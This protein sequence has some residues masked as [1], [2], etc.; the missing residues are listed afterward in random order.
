MRLYVLCAISL[1]ACAFEPGGPTEPDD[2]PLPDPGIPAD[3]D[4][5]VVDDPTPPDPP[6]APP[7]QCRV[8]NE[9]LGVVGLQVMG[10]Q[11]LFTFQAWKLGHGKPVGFTLTGP[12]NVRYE[13]RT[14][15]D[16][17]MI[18]ALVYD[19]RDEITRVDFCR[20]D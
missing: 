10:T 8:E 12:A 3:V 7:I 14:T 2:D 20:D 4:A 17:R 6:P 16:Q 11:G 5:A 18:E 9:N 13:V 1:A 19:G 15:R